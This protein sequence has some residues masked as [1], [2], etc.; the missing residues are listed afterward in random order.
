MR[1]R[2][3]SYKKKWNR[4]QVHSFAYIAS[5]YHNAGLLIRK[6]TIIT[7]RVVNCNS[8]SMSSVIFQHRA[9]SSFRARS[10]FMHEYVSRVLPDMEVEIGRF[11]RNRLYKYCCRNGASACIFFETRK[12]LRSW[13]SP[14]FKIHVL[15]NGW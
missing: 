3:A 10:S 2:H 12:F 6:N 9:K 1:S 5:S 13:Y 15:I 11:F 8:I 7:Q 14:N 4:A